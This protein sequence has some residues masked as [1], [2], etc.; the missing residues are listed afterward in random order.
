MISEE[1]GDKGSKRPGDSTDRASEKPEFQ[2]PG[3]CRRIM[4]QM[5]G[6]SFCGPANGREERTEQN[7]GDSPGLFG[8]LMLRMMKSC[9]GK[10]EQKESDDR[11]SYV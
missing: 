9:C 3:C 1:S 5:M 2:I 6:S 4:S 11:P 8:R 10:F 7:G